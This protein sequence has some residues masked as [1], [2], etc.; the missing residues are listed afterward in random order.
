MDLRGVKVIEVMRGSMVL[1][2]GM[3]SQE[4]MDGTGTL[5]PKGQQE[6]RGHLEPQGVRV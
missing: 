2:V 3:V 4:L 6:S 1:M 5:G